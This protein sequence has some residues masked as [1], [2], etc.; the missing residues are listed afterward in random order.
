LRIQIMARDRRRCVFTGW[1]DLQS[2]EENHPDVADIQDQDE[3]ARRLQVAHIISQSITSGITGL[4]ENAQAKAI[5]VWASSASAIL[6]R[7][8][9]IEIRQILGQ[10]DVHS[11]VNAILASSDPHMSFDDLSVSLEQS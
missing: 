5:L 7:F 2:I 3:D 10:L 11:P 6:D 1:G 9:G 4:S 8:V